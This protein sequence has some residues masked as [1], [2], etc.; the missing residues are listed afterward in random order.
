MATKT[1]TV[2][3]KCETQRGPILP[4]FFTGD[5]DGAELCFSC[6]GAELQRM[7]AGSGSGVASVP[8]SEA[9][10]QK[11]VAFQKRLAE[12]EAIHTVKIYAVMPSVPVETGSVIEHG[13]AEAKKQ[14]E[15][16]ER[17]VEEEG[18]WYA[19]LVA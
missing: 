6:A 4:M 1:I 9:L 14:I 11:T 7:Y 2:C 18:V 8:E 3:D 5:S 13:P 19:K 16:L 15:I 12:L 10:S 17:V